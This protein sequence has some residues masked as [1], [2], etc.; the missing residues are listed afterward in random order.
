[1]SP[2]SRGFRGRGRVPAGEEDRVPPAQL[3]VSSALAAAMA[4]PEVASRRSS[5]GR[6]T[7]M[8]LPG[9]AVYTCLPMACRVTE[10]CMIAAGRAMSAAALAVR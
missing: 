3:A 6:N 10:G 9:I 5:A 4:S 1:M 8:M 2:V 7:A